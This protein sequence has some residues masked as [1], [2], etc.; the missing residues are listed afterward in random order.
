MSLRAE[1][2]LAGLAASQWGLFTAPQAQQRGATRAQLTRLTQAGVVERLS[3]GVYLIRGAGSDE[4]TELRAAWLHLDPTRSAADRFDDGPAGAVISHASAANLFGFG[5]L[6]AD[7]HEFSLP[8]R[9]QTRRNDVILHRASLPPSDV[10]IHGGL[11]ATTPERT[12]VDLLTD[13]RDGEH[14]AGVL[15]G[16]VRARAIDVY[17]LARRIG[18]FAARYGVPVGDGDWLLDLLLRLDGSFEVALAQLL[19]RALRRTGTNFDTPLTRIDVG[20][21]A[22]P[23]TRRR[24]VGG[25]T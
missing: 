20:S 23:F 22:E 5:D 10:M 15:G 24:G 14:I 12:V 25:W 17:A 1:A 13:G 6:D 21:L 16:A 19:A 4:F 2:S 8:V 11:P 7:R 18:P 9:K 3:H